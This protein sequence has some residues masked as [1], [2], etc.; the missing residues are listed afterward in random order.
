MAERGRVPRVQEGR[1]VARED[2]LSEVEKQLRTGS[3]DA[4][5][6]F[7]IKPL[8]P[9]EEFLRVVGHL[10]QVVD[11]VCCMGKCD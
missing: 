5:L 3:Q 6:T 1:A 9:T 11:E 8:E 10:A 2:L 4:V 7:T